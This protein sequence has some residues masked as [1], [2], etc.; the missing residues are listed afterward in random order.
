MRYL[1]CGLFI[2]LSALSAQPSWA[3]KIEDVQAAVKAQC[4]KELD[5]STIL[6]LVKELF[7]TCAAGQKVEAEGCTL[8]CLKTNNGAVVGQ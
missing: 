1:K 8:N 4:G 5:N 6:R 3:G 2:L 7:I